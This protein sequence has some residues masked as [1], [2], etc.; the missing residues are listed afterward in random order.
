MRWAGVRA[1]RKTVEGGTHVN[2]RGYDQRGQT[3]A[4]RV[5][6]PRVSQ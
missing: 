2:E 3:I 1:K 4:A 5:D 6:F